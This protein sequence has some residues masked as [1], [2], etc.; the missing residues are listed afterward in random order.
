[1]PSALNG[2]LFVFLCSRQCPCA[3]LSDLGAYF[4]DQAGPQ[5]IEIDLPLPPEA[6]V[7]SAGSLVLL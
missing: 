4:V 7:S 2:V 5:L 3:A 1:M 6:R